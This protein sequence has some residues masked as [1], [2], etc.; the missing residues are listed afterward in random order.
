MSD[1]SVKPRIF[2]A[3]PG[4]APASLPVLAEELLARQK[5]DWPAL[6]A[7]YT[8]LE[9][10]WERRMAPGHGSVILQ[11]NPQRIRS[12]GA[13]VAPEAIQ[14]RPC[15]LCPGNLP[16]AQQAIDYRETFLILCNPFPIFG[17]HF[18]LAH[19]EHLA[20]SLSGAWPDLL[21]L[22]EDFHP[23]LAVLYNGPACGASAPDHLHFQA[24]PRAAIPI[25]QKGAY[26]R[27][28][29]R[30]A[31]GVTLFRT[32][33]REPPALV[34]EGGEREGLVPFL[35]KTLQAMPRLRAAPQEPLLNLFC[36]FEDG[37]WTVVLFPRRKHRPDVYYE[38]GD[39]QILISPGAVDMG[40]LLILPR[41]EDFQRLDGAG[42][43]RIFRE[44]ALSEEDLEAIAAAL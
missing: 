39:R 3:F 19:R 35:E 43:G 30:E 16:A 17:R 26:G 23:G 12:T 41:T 29:L 6:R 33:D 28:I 7:A 11:C 21:Q 10:V 40:G 18:T 38:T 20:Q 13:D 27:K 9:G 5:T 1:D 15:F 31:G 44:V 4:D 32:T 37:Q 22:A 2:A 24:V 36:H 14:A 25:L 34:L 42:I 8:A